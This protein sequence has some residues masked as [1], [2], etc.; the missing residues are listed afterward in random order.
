MTEHEI[1]QALDVGEDSDWEFKSAKGGIPG[2]LWETYSGMANTDGGTIVLGVGQHGDTFVLDGLDD[3][4]KVKKSFWDTINNRGKV[5]ANLLRDDQATVPGHW[6]KEG[7][8]RS[9]SPREPSAAAHL[10][11]PEPAGRHVSPQL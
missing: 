7:A 4:G 2:S 8:G 9:G 1:L 6:G 5:S 11:Q 10:C 3:P